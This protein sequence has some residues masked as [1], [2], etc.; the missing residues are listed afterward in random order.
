M[1]KVK[2][3]NSPKKLAELFNLYK[4]YAKNN[5]ILIHDYVGHSALEVSR[6]KERPLTIE[7]FEVYCHTNGIIADLGDYF[8]NKDGRYEEYA[9]ICKAIKNAIRCDQI[10]G[11]MVGIFS[12][13]ITQR[14]NNL[15]EQTETINQNLNVPLLN[16]DPLDKIID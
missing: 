10:E 3:I 6:K 16:I 7:G 14:L 1:S 5:P 15:K 4:D 12:A 13:S 9:P 2:Y 8:K 11:G